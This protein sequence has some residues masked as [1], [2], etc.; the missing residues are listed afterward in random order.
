MGDD[1]STSNEAGIHLY[2]LGMGKSVKIWKAAIK[3]VKPEANGLKAFWVVLAFFLF[4]KVFK[5]TA[6][7]A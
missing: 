5:L 6:W 4:E 2:C 7:A 1:V 3:T